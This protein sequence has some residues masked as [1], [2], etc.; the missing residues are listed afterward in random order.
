MT[1]RVFVACSEAES[2]PMRVLAFSLRETSSLPVEVAAIGSFGRAIPQPADL[3]NRPRTP[4]SFQRFLIPELCGFEGRAIYLDADMQVFTDIAA[5]WNQPME[6]HD[7]LAVR[8]G[9]GGRRGQ[10][11][12]M[13]LDCARLP[14]RVEE[15]VAGLDA[16]RY[17]YEQ[18]MAEM[19]L[20]PR[21]GRT[22]AP[23]WN[24]LE[25]YQ[26][27]VTKLLHYTDMNTQPW[28]SLRNPN[29]RHWVDCLR[30]AVA[31]GAIPPADVE[32][33]V[34]LGH[35]RPSLAAQLRGEADPA[36]LRALDH[37]FVA[38]YKSIR[39]GKPQAPWLTFQAGLRAYVIRALRPFRGWR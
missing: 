6:G 3:R 21:V 36:A 16:H 17:S 13:L 2:L 19:C 26:P 31:A 10:F 28:V 38:P 11:S 29:G 34:T 7:L 30:R 33:A 12:V 39:S 22:L 9:N 25:H 24:S 23:E 15:I 1:V 32:Q 37:A 35:V 27:G 20:V 5:L 14:W 4:F 18:L 8:E